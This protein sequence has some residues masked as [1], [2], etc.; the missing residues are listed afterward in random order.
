MRFSSTSIA[1][2]AVIASSETT[3]PPTASF[4]KVVNAI[5]AR[6]A[7]VTD[8]T[9]H[10][11]IETTPEHSAVDSFHYAAEVG[12]DEYDVE[13]FDKLSGK[14]L[15]MARLRYIRDEMDK[16]VVEYYAMLTVLEDSKLMPSPIYMS[17]RSG[18]CGRMI[19]IATPPVSLAEFRRGQNTSI[20]DALG[21]ASKALDL[22]DA[23]DKRG[24]YAYSMSTQS[25]R[26]VDG[27][28]LMLDSLRVDADSSDK[29]VTAWMPA[30]LQSILG[31]FEVHNGP[32][33]AGLPLSQRSATPERR[34]LRILADQQNS[35][36]VTEPHFVRR[37][38]AQVLGVS[39][40]ESAAGR[41]S[42]KLSVVS[43]LMSEAA[44][45]GFPMPDDSTARVG[46]TITANGTENAAVHRFALLTYLK[47]SG[48]LPQP[49]S[50]SE[51]SD[52]TD[53]TLV[54]AYAGEPLSSLPNADGEWDFKVGME[55][56]RMLAVLR[57]NGVYFDG[58]LDWTNVFWTM[59]SD[60]ELKL[61]IDSDRMV[62]D[63]IE[64]NLM[65]HRNVKDVGRIMEQM[66][67]KWTEEQYGREVDRRRIPN[68]SHDVVHFFERFE[69]RLPFVW[70]G[71]RMDYGQ[72]GSALGAADV[73]LTKM[74]QEKGIKA[75]RALAARLM[76]EEAVAI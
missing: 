15:G 2:L 68:I 65:S 20:V 74:L 55:L 70:T 8:P 17:K 71:S 41:F 76:A 3:L 40:M 36:L 29:V 16:R 66:L 25:L 59:G 19:V 24:F 37:V 49:L 72:T 12:R 75:G 47:G 6:D 10:C 48:Y 52:L 1:A 32:R 21:W 69:D 11:A 34:M 13:R 53:R 45:H 33:D 23:L 51:P 31:A 64:N 14:S 43:R 5:H 50:L 28:R 7:A 22:V 60:G 35:Q 67:A 73:A 39:T 9:P 4:R 57:N 42:A 38:F 26:V 58:P 63:V 30:F 54:Q 18:V 56:I 46:R 44:N 62:F 61:V 27:E